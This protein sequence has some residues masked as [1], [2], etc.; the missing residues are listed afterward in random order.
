MF[1]TPLGYIQKETIVTA[2]YLSAL[3]LSLLFS[4]LIAQQLDKQGYRNDS[5]LLE[6]HC[7]VIYTGQW[8]KRLGTV[9]YVL[10][11]LHELELRQII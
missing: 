11:I 1:R 4:F 5:L 8:G 10:N 9:T 2:N 7:S 6:N 3:K